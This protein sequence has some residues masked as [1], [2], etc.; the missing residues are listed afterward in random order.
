MNLLTEND[1]N[2]NL[3]SL[4]NN[5]KQKKIKQSVYN[6]VALNQKLK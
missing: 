1:K 4:S 2:S 3:N 6:I 5:N